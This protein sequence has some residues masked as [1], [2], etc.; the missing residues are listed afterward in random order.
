MRVS[1]EMNKAQWRDV[2]RVQPGLL[3]DSMKG[4]LK[5][6]R[7]AM[8]AWCNDE[9]VELAMGKEPSVMWY[10]VHDSKLAVSS[11]TRL[12]IAPKITIS[13][14]LSVKQANALYR[15]M[16][17]NTFNT[18]G[19]QKARNCIMGSIEDELKKAGY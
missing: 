11:N 16:E 2:L 13:A 15:I 6:N 1:P 7:E 10:G 8:V 5:A 12:R 3:N 14:T 17:E 4:F 9:P 18:E 19:G